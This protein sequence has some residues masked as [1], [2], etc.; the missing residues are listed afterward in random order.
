[1]IMR[2]KFGEFV[3]E[4]R[5]E[6]NLKLKAFA[7]L[8]GIS[9]VYES[10]IENAKRP[11]PSQ[12]ILL[13]ISEVLSLS[14]EEN[15]RMLGL[16]ELSHRKSVFPQEV[17]DYIVDRPYVIETLRLAAERGVSEDQW[18]AFRNLIGVKTPRS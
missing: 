8:I 15:D 13:N 11:A 17:L 2:K 1:M 16:A 9:A 10:Y 6:K 14:P 18:A 12:K 7:E 5:L 3:R 4:K